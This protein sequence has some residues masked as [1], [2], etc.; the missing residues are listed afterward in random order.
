MFKA[1][2][3][4]FQDDILRKKQIALTALLHVM[5]R[6]RHGFTQTVAGYVRGNLFVRSTQ[7]ILKREKEKQLPFG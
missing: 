6:P 3:C 1:H 2:I 7:I 5:F 4:T